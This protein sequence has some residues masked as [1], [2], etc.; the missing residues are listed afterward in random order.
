M[1]IE[2]SRAKEEDFSYIKEKLQKYLLDTSNVNWKQFFVAKIQ[3][4]IA[5][6]GRM[7]DHGASF[8]VASLGVDYY[9]RKKGIGK[10]MLQFLVQEA[11][12]RDAQKPIYGVTHV[13]KFVS[14]CGFRQIREDYPDYL[15]YKRKHICQ[16]EESRISIMKW[17]D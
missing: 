11:R 16:L 3:N 13:E 5:A 8:E 2:F 17:V 7:I 10:R 6:F 12:R 9:Q 4:K 14:S 1:H 15:D